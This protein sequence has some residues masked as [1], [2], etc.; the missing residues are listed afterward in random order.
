VNLVALPD[1][2]DA[3]AAA[4]PGCRFAT[5]YRAVLQVG[6]LRAGEWVAVT[7]AAASASRRR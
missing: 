1:S 4:G 7:V 3:D 6:R 5:A 2:V